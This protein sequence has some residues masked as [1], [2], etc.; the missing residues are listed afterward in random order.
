VNLT[1]K[2]LTLKTPNISIVRDK[3]LGQQ[4]W[5]EPTAKAKS[6]KYNAEVSELDKKRQL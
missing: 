6:K 3:Y 5:G 1:D 4:R 2:G